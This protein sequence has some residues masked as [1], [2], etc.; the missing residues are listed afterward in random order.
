MNK[1][2]SWLRAAASSPSCTAVAAAR[3]FS[4]RESRATT[5]AIDVRFVNRRRNLGRFSI[6]FGRSM[7]PTTRAVRGSP[8]HSSVTP[9]PETFENHSQ[10]PPGIFNHFD[11]GKA[12]ALLRLSI[13]PSIDPSHACVCVWKEPVSKSRRV[14]ETTSQGESFAAKRAQAMRADFANGVSE[15]PRPLAFGEG[16]KAVGDLGTGLMSA[17]TPSDRRAREE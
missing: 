14:E 10:K 1:K 7:V 4:G 12:T 5:L 9:N 6:R 13:D 11:A 8:E 2:R 16:Q 17:R 15:R 3:R